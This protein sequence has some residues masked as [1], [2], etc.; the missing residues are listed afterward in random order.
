MLRN[1]DEVDERSER[2]IRRGQTV[3]VVIATTLL[4]LFAVFALINF[5]DVTVDYA[6]DEA[7][8]PLAV[9][10]VGSLLL[11]ALLGTFWDRR[12]D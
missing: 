9:V 7:E 10:I 12:S 3:K 8:L 4:L 11:G 1:H 2:K 6:F 5:Q